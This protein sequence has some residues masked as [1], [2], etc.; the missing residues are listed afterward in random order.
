MRDESSGRGRMP[1]REALRDI[2]IAYVASLASRVGLRHLAD[3]YPHIVNKLGRLK[4]NIERMSYLESLLLDDRLNRKGFT[5]PA[6]Q[7]MTALREY[8]QGR[9]L[10]FPG[11]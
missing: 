8:L 6:L 7:E 4:A 5:L 1:Q 2:G 10:R 9:V 11:K 3:N